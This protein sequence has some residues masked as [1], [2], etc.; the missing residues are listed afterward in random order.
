V[1]ISPADP[2]PGDTLLC[3]VDVD[4]PDADYD[5]ISYSAV[6]TRD[7]ATTT[8]ST[9][10]FSNDTI[11]SS[12]TSI[13]EA[14]VCTVTPNDGEDEGATD[15]ASVT[16]SLPTFTEG[17]TDTLL[18]VGTPTIEM[19]GFLTDGNW[20]PDHHV[21]GMDGF[22]VFE[23]Q[24]DDYFER[25]LTLEGGVTSGHTLDEYWAG[26]GQVVFDGHM[27]TLEADTAELIKFDLSSETEVARASLTGV[28][29]DAAYAYAW[30]VH[31]T[32]DLDTDGEDLMIIHSS[33][34]AGG[35]FQVSKIHPGTLAVLS[36]WTAPSGH[37]NEYN[38]AFIA[39]GVLYAMEGFWADTT[40]SY[41][42]E[43][44]T[45]S[46]W[47]PSIAWDVIHYLTATQYSS[48]HDTIYAYDGGRL[49]TFTPTWE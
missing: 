41:A 9:S 10:T 48:L 20:G 13:G 26:T 43:I 35:K 45:T 31:T 15:D 3:E 6:W 33:S 29:G 34:A 38:N 7:G 23:G 42:W 47:D 8:G 32:T 24:D 12:S 37:K 44:G 40:I 46:V 11:P 2:G 19:T 14:W 22:W 18:S 5:T 4:A 36:T 30:G 17:C 28:S 21:A 1:S 27:Y 39:C 16:I 49:L 25:Y